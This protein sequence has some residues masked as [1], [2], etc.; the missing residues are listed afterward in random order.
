[1]LFFL[2]C[3]RLLAQLATTLQMNNYPS[4]GNEK[5]ID[6]FKCFISAIN[7]LEYRKKNL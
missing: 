4:L 5:D 2:P 6:K 1:M 3:T 7:I